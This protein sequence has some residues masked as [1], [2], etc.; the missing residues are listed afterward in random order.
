MS[1]RADSSPRPRRVLSIRWIVSGAAIA[2]TAVTVLI[3]GGLWERST[4]QAL[5]RES[6]TRLMLAARNLALTSTQALPL[7]QKVASSGSI[8]S[9]SV[10]WDIR[11]PELA[12]TPARPERGRAITPKAPPVPRYA[13]S[14]F[15][16][17]T[18]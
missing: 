1:K 15:W 3:V 17:R 5:N 2:L 12:V 13:S 11:T 9:P 4:R 7:V 10:I 16:A 18:S 8:W 6:G 14:A